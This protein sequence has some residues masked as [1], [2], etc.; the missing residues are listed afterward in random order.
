MLRTELDPTFPIGVSSWDFAAIFE[1][2]LRVYARNE[3]LDP[4]LVMGAMGD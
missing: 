4:V 3:P 1:R 2:P